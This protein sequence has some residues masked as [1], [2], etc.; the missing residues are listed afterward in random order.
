MT[1]NEFGPILI[2]R[3]VV[4][5]RAMT[6]AEAKEEG[7]DIDLGNPPIVV[8]FDDGTKLYASADEEG[9]GAGAL[10]GENPDGRHFELGPVGDPVRPS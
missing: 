5:V 8:V 7:W 2:G 3:K 9:N 10:F 6:Q 4:D 1:E